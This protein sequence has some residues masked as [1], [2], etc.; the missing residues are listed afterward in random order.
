MFG[1]SSLVFPSKD[2]EGWD[3]WITNTPTYEAY[4]KEVRFFR[5]FN[6]SWIFCWEYRYQNYLF[7]SFPLSIV[8][9]YKVRWWNEYK[10]MLCR[11]E[12]VEYF[13]KTKTKK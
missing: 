2:K 9:I 10:T 5:T 3:F 7:N 11:K 4:T 6:I 1:C 13:C 8:W 12:N